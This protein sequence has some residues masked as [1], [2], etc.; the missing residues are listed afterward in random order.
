MAG[1]RRATVSG[2]DGDV[3]EVGGSSPA[4][5]A[6]GS[7]TRRN[8]PRGATV[9]RILA[10]LTILSVVGLAA[11]AMALPGTEAGLELTDPSLAASS[12]FGVSRN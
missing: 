1:A 5:R 7:A 9:R 8:G 3:A 6:S 12:P 10:P 4:R 2:N 11:A